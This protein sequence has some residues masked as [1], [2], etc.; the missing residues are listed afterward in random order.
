MCVW[1]KVK[2]CKE[3]RLKGIKG[4][5]TQQQQQDHLPRLSLPTTVIHVLMSS[6]DRSDSAF[7]S[8][9]TPSSLIMSGTSWDRPSTETS[10]S[11]VRRCVVRWQE[12]PL[13]DETHTHKYI[14]VQMSVQ[15]AHLENNTT[16][17]P[18]NVPD[19]RIPMETQHYC[20]IMLWPYSGYQTALS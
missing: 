11:L 2:G 18:P 13:R 7:K 4:L 3:K 17:F 10:C 19:T 9:L 16:I 15:H 20:W 12:F 5:S 6:L 14:C 1:L 8:K